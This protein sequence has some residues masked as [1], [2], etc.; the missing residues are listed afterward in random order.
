MLERR[1]SHGGPA[2][3]AH[4]LHRPS[5]T[6]GSA[7]SSDQTRQVGIVAVHAVE[8]LDDD[9]HALEFVSAGRQ[10]LLELSR[11][12]WGKTRRA[13][14]DS[15]LPVTALLCT[16]ASQIT[17]S[18]AR[19]ELGDHSDIRG[20]PAD[21]QQRILGAIMFG[22][23]T[24]QRTMHRALPRHDACSPS[25]KSRIDRSPLCSGADFRMPVETEIVVG[26]E[27][28]QRAS[29][30]LGTRAGAA[31]LHAKIGIFEPKLFTDRALQ[32]QFVVSGERGEIGILPSGCAQFSVCGNR[33][34]CCP[35]MRRETAAVRGQRRRKAVACS[36]KHPFC[37]RRFVGQHLQRFGLPSFDL[38]VVM[39]GDRRNGLILAIVRG[40]KRG[41]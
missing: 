35:S 10:D 37:L 26:R 22:K 21:E 13:A 8:T 28:Q 25:Q 36:S 7:S 34:A 40:S 38:L 41:P 20:V 19:N 30:D 29:A 23:R 5:A 4:A 15:T 11:S 2:C 33:S 16:A 24:F 9:Q 12:L 18:L 39:F 14:P 1:H 32:P 31:V 27:I 3:R 17:K 6:R